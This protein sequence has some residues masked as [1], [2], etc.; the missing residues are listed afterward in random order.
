MAVAKA[1]LAITN[2]RVFDGERA[3]ANVDVAIDGDKVVAVGPHLALPPKTVVV[4]GTGRTLLPGLFDGHAHV[5][6][7]SQLEQALAF[8]VTTVLDMFAIPDEVKKI[9]AADQPGRADLRS[10]GIC[11]TAP[12][13]HGTEYG[14]EIP[15]ITRPEDA[16]AFVDARIAEGSDYL[17]I[18]YDDGSAYNRDKPDPIPSI[19]AA[20]MTALVT[21]AHARHILAMVHIG[22]YDEARA[23]FASGADGIVHLF[24]DVV[25]PDDFG[26]T[27]AKGHGFVT[28]T[29]DVLRTL[30]GGT[31]P[32]GTDPEL[33]PYLG[34]V[35]KSNL[36]GTFPIR[37]KATPDS[38]ETA[39]R[40]LLAAGVPILVGTDAPN[41]GTV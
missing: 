21:A 2:V 22:D 36:V 30:Q 29:L 34:P 24:R 6:D 41:N 15:T 7:A 28:P 25:P 8:G 33:G 4:D 26:A 17:K 37:A 23:A 20:T 35:D 27:V 14:F 3:I 40:Q 5:S 31:S 38:A 39:I 13:G 32:I 11:A 1:Q 9:K 18:I 12:G 16:Q 19:D 10:A